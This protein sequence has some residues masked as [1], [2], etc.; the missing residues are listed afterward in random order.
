MEGRFEQSVVSGRDPTGEFMNFLTE[1][2]SASTGTAS[3]CRN[4][5]RADCALPLADR[6]PVRPRGFEAPTSRRR[7]RLLRLSRHLG[8]LSIFNRLS[9]LAQARRKCRAMTVHLT[10]N[11]DASRFGSGDD[12]IDALDLVQL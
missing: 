7:R 11:A 5:F 9:S 8:E 2:G 6:G 1:R 3:P 10:E 4:A 12:V